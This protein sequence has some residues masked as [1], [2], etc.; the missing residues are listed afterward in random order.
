ML[1]PL[2]FQTPPIAAQLTCTRFLNPVFS[3]FMILT[4]HT[5]RFTLMVPHITA[6][7]AKR[8]RPMASTRPSVR[9][10]SCDLINVSERTAGWILLVVSMDPP[11]IHADTRSFSISGT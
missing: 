10:S 9:L 3:P 1:S 11:S 4:S 6:A 7:T 5:R 2:I 8:T